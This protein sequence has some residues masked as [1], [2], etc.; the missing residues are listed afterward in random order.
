VQ[1]QQPLEGNSWK[2]FLQFTMRYMTSFI[3][4]HSW[5][6]PGA[7]CHFLKDRSIHYYNY[8]ESKVSKWFYRFYAW[9]YPPSTTKQRSSWTTFFFD[10]QLKLSSIHQ[11]NICSIC[12][13]THIKLAH[14]AEYLDSPHAWCGLSTRS[15]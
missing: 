15:A 2:K 5:S 14:V 9:I 1:A 4:E 7:I 8:T 3:V 6:L 10:C 11:T 12:K 13:W